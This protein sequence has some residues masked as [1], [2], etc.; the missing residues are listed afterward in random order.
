MKLEWKKSGGEKYRK[1]Q[2]NAILYNLCSTNPNIY[3]LKVK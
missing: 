2:A 3:H 1:P